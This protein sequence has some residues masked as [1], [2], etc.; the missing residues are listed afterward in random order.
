[1]GTAIYVSRNRRILFWRFIQPKTVTVINFCHGWSCIF[2]LYHLPEVKIIISTNLHTL[3]ALA[4]S[5]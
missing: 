5:K 2:C 4:G 3:S 1:L